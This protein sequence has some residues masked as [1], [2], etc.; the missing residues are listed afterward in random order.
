MKL[1]KYVLLDNF[2]FS[3]DLGKL[4]GAPILHANGDSPEDVVRATR[5]ALD[6]RRKFRKDVFVELHCYRRWGHNELDDPSFTN[7]KLYSQIQ[8]RR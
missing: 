4:V 3:S 7:P 2:R 6:Y 5:L 8:S 1:E